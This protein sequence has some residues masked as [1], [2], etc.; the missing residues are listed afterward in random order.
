MTFLCTID[1]LDNDSLTLVFN[2]L[3][4]P[5]NERLEYISNPNGCSHKSS[6]HSQ[7]HAIHGRPRNLRRR[8]GFVLAVRKDWSASF[9]MRR[10]RGLEGFPWPDQAK[11]SPETLAMLVELSVNLKDRRQ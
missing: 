4:K 1:D 6:T 3:G 9:G 10:P 8:G 5:L 11:V 2:G 7:H